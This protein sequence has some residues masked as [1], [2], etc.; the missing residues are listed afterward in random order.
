MWHEGEKGI[1]SESGPEGPLSSLALRYRKI[2]EYLAGQS[3]TSIQL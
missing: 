3:A 1:E 2:Q